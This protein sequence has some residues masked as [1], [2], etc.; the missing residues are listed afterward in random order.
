MAKYVCEGTLTNLPILRSDHCPI[1]LDTIL[2]AQFTPGPARFENWWLMTKESKDIMT[3]VR[4]AN[5]VGSPLFTILRRN[6]EMMKELR[7]WNK[8]VHGS[9][10]EKIWALQKELEEVQNKVYISQDAISRA[11]S[12]RNELDK[13]L[14]KEECMWAQKA[15]V[16]WLGLGDS[17]TGFFDAATKGRRYVNKITVIKD[18][19]GR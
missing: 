2:T 13:T 10:K 4:M 3:K 11:E 8:N 5:S 15:K 14:T 6:K 12:L 17:N 9:F 7:W 16:K 19:S 1:L 18:N